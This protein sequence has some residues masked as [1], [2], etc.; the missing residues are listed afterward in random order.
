MGKR[1]RVKRETFRKDCLSADSDGYR[2]IVFVF[3][4]KG[5]RHRVWTQG[6]FSEF[7]QK[8]ILIFCGARLKQ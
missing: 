4:E 3:L 2:G 1:S 5:L 8:N 7:R 6:E